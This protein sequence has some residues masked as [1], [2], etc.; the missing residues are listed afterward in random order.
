MGGM[1]KPKIPKADTSALKAAE[2]QRKKAK[3]EAEAAQVKLD[4]T[5]EANR[6]RKK[7]VAAS[8]RASTVLAGEESTNSLLGS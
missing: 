8:G 7:N 3:Q 2:E 4:A 5:E 6:Q 1:F